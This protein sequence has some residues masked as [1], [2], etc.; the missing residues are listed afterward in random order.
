MSLSKPF[1]T[2]VR[3]AL[4]TKHGKESVLA[5]ILGKQCGAIVEHTDQFDTD[6]LGT[7][8]GDVPRLLSQREAAREKAMLATKL[9]GLKVGLGSEGSSA[10]DP[11]IGLTPWHYEIIVLV[12]LDLGLE[13][14]GVASGA[15]IAAPQCTDDWP[16]ALRFASLAGFPSHQLLVRPLGESAHLMRKGIGEFSALKDAF[17]WAC[18]SSASQMATIEND[19]RAHCN[20]TRMT[21][22]KKATL[23]LSTKMNQRCPRCRAPGFSNFEKIAGLPCRDCGVPTRLPIAIKQRCRLCPHEVTNS[24]H[25]PTFAD[26]ARCDFC[27]P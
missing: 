25:T 21:V 6:Q 11:Y 4:L 18:R 9:T 20:P 15:A 13:I 7:F 3:M 26:P 5:P 14:E 24:I 23:D 12:D 17:Y 19:L 27:N 2:D 8:T 16:E 1:Y 10:V 22:I